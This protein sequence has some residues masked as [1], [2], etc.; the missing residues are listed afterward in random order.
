MLYVDGTIKSTPKFFYQPFT[1]HGLSNCHYTSFVYFL[2]ANKHKT[3][4]EDVFRHTV[5]EAAKRRV[6]VCQ[7]LFMLTSKPPFPTQWRQCG[8]AVK[9]TQVVCILGQSCWRKIPSLGLSKQQG[10]KDSE[11]SQ[12]LKKIPRLSLYHQRKSATDLRFT[13]YPV[14]WTTSEWNSFA[15]T[16]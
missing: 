2:L 5:L 7:Q 8:Q 9:L 1:I 4:Y 11:V 3:S 12:F 10:K 6:N 13:L 14:F 16:C 15:T